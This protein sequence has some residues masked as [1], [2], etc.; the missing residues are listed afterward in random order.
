MR[1]LSCSIELHVQSNVLQGH[2]GSVSNQP[3]HKPGTG[4]ALQA[5]AGSGRGYAVASLLCRSR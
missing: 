4:P 2:V 1:M 3:G 5:A